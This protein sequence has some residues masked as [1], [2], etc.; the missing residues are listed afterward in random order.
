MT[1]SPP[2][3]LRKHFSFTSKRRPPSDGFKDSIYLSFSQKPVSLSVR[4]AWKRKTFLQ[5]FRV[6]TRYIYYDTFGACKVPETET[7]G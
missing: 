5:W 3:R 7:T 1:Y 4:W 6:V 2:D